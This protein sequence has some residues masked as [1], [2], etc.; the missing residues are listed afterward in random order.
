MRR[1]ETHNAR[2]LARRASTSD[3][4]LV[5]QLLRA[6]PEGDG[7]T[8]ETSASS[9]APF[10]AALTVSGSSSSLSLSD[11]QLWPGVFLDLLPDCE[12]P[13]ALALAADGWPSYSLRAS[14]AGGAFVATK[15]A[16]TFC[17]ERDL[18]KGALLFSVCGTKTQAEQWVQQWV[19]RVRRRRECVTVSLNEWKAGG[20]I[21]L[22]IK[23]Q[24]DK[25]SE[26]LESV[27]S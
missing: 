12:Q 22:Q 18:C 3:S 26:W 9:P 25:A 27:V 7:R 17:R 10:S 1:A 19:W 13:T 24:G 23:L 16:F 20:L 15:L 5:S 11:P 21:R 8:A 4:T 14:L 2:S 6:G